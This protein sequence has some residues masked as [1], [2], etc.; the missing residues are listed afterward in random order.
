[1]A[2]LRDRL[3]TDL[4]AAMRA[5]DVIR[6]ETIRLL[7]AAAKNAEIDRRGPLDDPALQA[8][9]QKQI[10]QRREAIDLYQRGGRPELAERERAE[11]AVLETYL[12]AQLDR[13]AI[14]AVTRL[15]IERIG[16]R[17]AADKSKVMGPLMAELR[18]R[19]D[20]R[21]VNEVVT[22]LLGG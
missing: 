3:R 16:A 5:G 22:E 21:L 7:E 9:V 6:R 19:A 15:V 10:K 18:G 12:P 14:V 1:M 4:H 11:I 17:S 20:G 2:A 8:I 13:D